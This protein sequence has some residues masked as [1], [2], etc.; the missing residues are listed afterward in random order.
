VLT[1]HCTDG[2]GVPDAAAVN[3]AVA[4]A[5]TV[6]F[7][8]LVVIAGAEFTVSVAGVDVALPA[9]FV[10]TAS[11]RLAFCEAVVVKVNVAE[12]APDTGV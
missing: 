2:A 1:C 11:Y 6:T 4:G 5:T 8:G 12:V 3:V 9:E 7:A 10:K